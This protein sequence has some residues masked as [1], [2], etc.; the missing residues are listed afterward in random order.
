MKEGFP[1]LLRCINDFDKIWLE[2]GA[3][4]QGAVNVRTGGQLAAI[5][6]CH[7]PAVQDSGGLRNLNESFVA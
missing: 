1:F 6:R 3:A 2:R 7:R 4:D 5:L